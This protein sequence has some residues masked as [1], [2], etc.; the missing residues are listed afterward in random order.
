MVSQC[1]SPSRQSVAS[2]PS[3]V[4]AE[5]PSPSRCNGQ[6][7]DGS[8]A[9]S[10]PTL[11]TSSKQSFPRA[12]WILGKALQQRAQ[13]DAQRAQL[14]VQREREEAVHRDAEDRAIR[15]RSHPAIKQIDKAF[16]AWVKRGL[17]RLDIDVG[18]IQHT[19][20]DAQYIS[21]CGM[22]LICAQLVAQGY[23]VRYV[24]HRPML[25]SGLRC[26]TERIL[27][28]IRYIPKGAHSCR[29]PFPPITLYTHKYCLDYA[30]HSGCSHPYWPS[31]VNQIEEW[32]REWE[33]AHVAAP[34]MDTA[35]GAANPWLGAID[36]QSRGQVIP[37][38]GQVSM[39]QFHEEE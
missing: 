26:V 14:D 4:T 22:D 38:P 31:K 19:E 12:Q 28:N 33:V 3:S 1:S 24:V 39:P 27:L 17:S 20:K 37:K 15:D 23:D 13:L 8:H 30:T 18:L 36:P 6:A 32:E 9:E 35:A 34:R 5:C 16:S 10:R 25:P 7:N 11:P 29:I 21:R 2:H